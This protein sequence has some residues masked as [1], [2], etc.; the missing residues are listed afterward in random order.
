MISV[1]V[2]KSQNRGM[3]QSLGESL[4]L[5]HCWGKLVCKWLSS[6]HWPHCPL[7]SN[8]RSSHS[9]HK[10]DKEKEMHTLR[11][12]SLRLLSLS[13]G[14]QMLVTRPTDSC[15]FLSSAQGYTSGLVG[16]LCSV[17]KDNEP[18]GT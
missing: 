13:S 16:H 17:L 14:K 5:Q 10:Q 9:P 2:P 7:T 12:S 18:L 8:A 3:W 15:H 6:V 4:D 11:G 1:L